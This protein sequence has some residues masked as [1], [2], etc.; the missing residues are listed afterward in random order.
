[1]EDLEHREFKFDNINDLNKQLDN[2]NEEYLVCNIKSLNQYFN[3]LSVFLKSLL[4]KS[5]VIICM[6]TWNL[7]RH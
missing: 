7:K 5:S 4:N 2:Y 3:K 6:E 1:M